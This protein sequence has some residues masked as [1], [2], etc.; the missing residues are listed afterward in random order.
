MKKF[1]DISR[2]ELQNAIVSMLD[3]LDI[4]GSII[5]EYDIYNAIYKEQEKAK[6]H[7]RSTTLL[8]TNT[9]FSSLIEK[10]STEE[11][12]EALLKELRRVGEGYKK[13]ENWGVVVIKK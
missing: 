7:E 1:K 2:E 10:L 3:L 12:K 11:G 13:G 5:G 4:S 6:E 9:D 8:Y